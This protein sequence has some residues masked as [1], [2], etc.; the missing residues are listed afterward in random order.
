VALAVAMALVA[1]CGGN[2]EDRFS[3]AARKAATSTT[4]PTTA[5]TGD[6]GGSGG[7]TG[8]PS[9]ST[10]TVAPA[11]P[12]APGE[13]LVAAVAAYRAALGTDAVQALQFTI[14]FPVGGTAYAALQ[15]QDPAQPAN[16]DERDWRDGKVGEPSPVRLTGTGTLA[17]NLFAMSSVNWAAVA[18]ALPGAKDLVAQK[19]GNPLAD[20]SGVTHVIVQKDLPFS[21]H[22]VA[23]VYVDGGA[24]TTGGYVQYLADGTLDKVQA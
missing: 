9:R 19:L 18:D 16:V 14:H 15:S 22:T 24:R 1:G 21:D 7:A 13:A 3:A 5:P 8:E 10:S 4:T 17:E 11:V 6:A 2:D 12:A 20:S 23:R